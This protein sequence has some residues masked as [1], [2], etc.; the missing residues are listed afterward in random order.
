MCA[1]LIFMMKNLNIVDSVID[2]HTGSIIIAN[3]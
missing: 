1:S 3:G 2:A